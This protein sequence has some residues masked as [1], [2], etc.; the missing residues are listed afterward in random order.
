MRREY[1]RASRITNYHIISCPSCTMI[2]YAGQVI[3]IIFCIINIIGT[4]ET[5]S[6]IPCGLLELKSI[7]QATTNYLTT[8]LFHHHHHPLLLGHWYEIMALY[9]VKL[10]L[11]E[12]SASRQD[13]G[14]SKKQNHQNQISEHMGHATDVQMRQEI[15]KSRK[16]DFNRN[17]TVYCCVIQ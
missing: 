9:Y 13:R 3:K 7:S 5:S 12:I 10:I 4:I 15:Q 2:V 16:N 11:T 17:L 1:A 8:V 6:Q 14:S